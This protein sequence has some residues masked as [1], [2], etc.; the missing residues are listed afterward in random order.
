MSSTEDALE[1]AVPSYVFD[2]LQ[3]VISAANE[4]VRMAVDGD[5]N[6]GMFHIASYLLETDGIADD[7][8]RDNCWQPFAPHSECP[9][10]SSVGS[11][12][13]SGHLANCVYN[14]MR[15]EGPWSGAR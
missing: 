11:L 5:V 2:A 8:V 14:P 3:G 10:C 15:S 7:L 12:V 1:G 13:S 9:G 6:G 4:G